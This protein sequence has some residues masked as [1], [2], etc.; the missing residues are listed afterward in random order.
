MG[1]SK[2]D[3]FLESL[4]VQTSSKY[5]R[6]PS[7]RVSNGSPETGEGTAAGE[8]SIGSPLHNSFFPVESSWEPSRVNIDALLSPFDDE[9]LE[10]DFELLDEEACISSEPEQALP[11]DGCNIPTLISR[12]ASL[13]QSVGCNLGFSAAFVLKKNKCS[14]S[15][16][17]RD[18]ALH[19]MTR[20]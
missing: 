20:P 10:A 14:Q 2:E 5:N 9:L 4:P 13:L 18:F 8:V 7:F 15:H 12:S 3:G 6:L 1:M 11:P 19:S 17:P 16:C